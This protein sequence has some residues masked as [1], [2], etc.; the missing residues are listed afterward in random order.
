[1]DFFIVKNFHKKIKMNT[2]SEIRKSIKKIAS[3]KGSSFFTAKVENVD[4]EV[5]SVKVD[6]LLLTDVR[7]RTVVNN[8]VS[9]ILITPEIGRKILTF[10]KTV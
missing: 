8:E 5:C 7:L 2:L 10:C 6:D 3:E 4:G 9:K 1:M